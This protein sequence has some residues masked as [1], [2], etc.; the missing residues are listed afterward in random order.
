MAE[1]CRHAEGTD[2]VIGRRLQSLTGNKMFGW[3]CSP[4]S[5]S[6]NEREGDSEP[7]DRL[8]PPWAGVPTVDQLLALSHMVIFWLSR[9]R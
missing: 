9:K 7:V 2:K 3:S 6:R 8:L 4:H 1:F 5:T